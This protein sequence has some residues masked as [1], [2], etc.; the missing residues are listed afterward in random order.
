MSATQE[1]T[2][3]TTPRKALKS[4]G[5]VTAVSTSCTAL[6][7]ICQGELDLYVLDDV[8]VILSTFDERYPI[9]TCKA[10]NLVRKAVGLVKDN[11]QDTIEPQPGETCAEDNTDTIP[12]LCLED[13]ATFDLAQEVASW[14]DT[15]RNPSLEWD[16]TNLQSALGKLTHAVETSSL[17]KANAKW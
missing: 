6:G 9:I 8:L 10:T 7:Q 15:N 4:V 11:L 1:L 16:D 12:P 3:P 17:Y 13:F 2:P 5:G 14:Y